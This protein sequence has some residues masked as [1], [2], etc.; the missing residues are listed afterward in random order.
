M[1]FAKKN[2]YNLIQLGFQLQR[3]IVF[4]LEKKSK[5]KSEKKQISSKDKVTKNGQEKGI[6]YFFIEVNYFFKS[7]GYFLKDFKLT[8]VTLLKDSVE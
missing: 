5:C 2:L 6:S 1:L 4:Y 8:L 7:N 3:N